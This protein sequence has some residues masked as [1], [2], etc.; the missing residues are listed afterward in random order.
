MST[1]T[2]EALAARIAILEGI[3]GQELAEKKPVVGRGPAL[4]Q[5]G[6]ER[7]KRA[8]SAYQLF[9]NANRAEVQTQLVVEA[10]EGVKLARGAALSELESSDVLLCSRRIR[11]TAIKRE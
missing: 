4:K 10:G 2:I 9:C 11:P 7:K 8:L 1:A 6:T 3:I 5:D